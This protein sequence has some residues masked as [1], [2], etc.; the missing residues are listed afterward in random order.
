MTLSIKYTVPARIHRRRRRRLGAQRTLH[1]YIDSAR[2]ATIRSITDFAAIFLS[3]SLS[4]RWLSLCQRLAARPSAETF[5]QSSKGRTSAGAG[6]SMTPR[7]ALGARG[8]GHGVVAKWERKKE[9]RESDAR[10]SSN[11]RHLLPLGRLHTCYSAEW[12]KRKKKMFACCLSSSDDGSASPS[13]R[14][15][16]RQCVYPS[17]MLI[18]SSI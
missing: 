17:Y 8:R 16:S 13:Q 18:R 1:A 9:E 4:Q 10:E 5:R 12:Q 14:S 7:R 11:D 15:H 6:G 2:C 3:Q